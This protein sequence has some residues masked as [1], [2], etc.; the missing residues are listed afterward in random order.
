MEQIQPGNPFGQPISIGPALGAEYVTFGIGGTPA[1]IVPQETLG[2][3]NVIPWGA[4]PPEL[5]QPYQVAPP[6]AYDYLQG[7]SG[8]ARQWQ[9]A[10][11]V[12]SS[13]ADYSSSQRQTDVGHSYA[14]V[15][16]TAAERDAQRA[17][18]SVSFWPGFL[19]LLGAFLYCAPPWWI[20]A[21]HNPT[22]TAMSAGGV[23][24]A[25]V[26]IWACTTVIAGPVGVF[27]FLAGVASLFRP[28]PARRSSSYEHDF[29]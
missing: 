27:G 17:A 22:A 7:R 5:Q 24:Q 4:V 18:E 1:N 14:R 6:G 21:T 19:S 11:P 9:P 20:I 12:R 15:S 3:R 16:P 25:L 28:K 23:M 10:A 2:T 8:A 13:Y 29:R 26:G